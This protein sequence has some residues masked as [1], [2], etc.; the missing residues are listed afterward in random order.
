[1]NHI[2]REGDIIIMRVGGKDEWKTI[3]AIRDALISNPQDLPGRRNEIEPQT[4]VTTE[5]VNSPR[6]LAR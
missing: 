4:A 6:A 5:N 3:H 2:R 1:M